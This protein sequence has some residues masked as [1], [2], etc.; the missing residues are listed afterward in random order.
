[1][2]KAPARGCT[3]AGMVEAGYGALAPRW[4][5][6]ASTCSPEVYA[7]M[8]MAIQCGFVGALMLDRVLVGAV[9]VPAGEERV[10]VVVLV[11]SGR[12]WGGA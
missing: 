1:M 2:P 6:M 10:P 3:S 7:T 9:N 5:A 4:A 12:R 8:C 11:R